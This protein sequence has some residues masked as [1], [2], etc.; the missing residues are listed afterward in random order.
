MVGDSEKTSRPKTLIFSVVNLKSNYFLLFSSLNNQLLKNQLTHNQQHLGFNS[1]TTQNQNSYMF[2]ESAAQMDDAVLRRTISEPTFKVKSALQTRLKQRSHLNPVFNSKRRF[3]THQQQ[4]HQTNNYGFEEIPSAMLSKAGPLRFDKD[5][6]DQSALT[7]MLAAAILQQQQQQQQQQNQ[8]YQSFNAQC[9]RMGLPGHFLNNFASQSQP[10]LNS[11]NLQALLENYTMSQDQRAQQQISSLSM[12]DLHNCQKLQKNIQSAS[13]IPKFGNI[14][15]VEEDSGIM[16][17]D[18]MRSGANDHAPFMYAAAKPLG[19]NHAH[20]LT[21]K[22]SSY[23]EPFLLN[24]HESL[25]LTAEC[26]SSTLTNRKLSNKNSIDIAMQCDRSYRYT[27]GIVY[28]ARMIKHECTCKNSNN[29]IETPDRLKAIYQ[30]LKRKNLLDDCEVIKANKLASLDDIALCHN[31]L[32]TTIFGTNLEER[33]KLRPEYFQHYLGSICLGE[34]NGYALVSDQDNS[35][36]EEYTPV[37]CRAAIAGTYDLAELVW[38]GKLRNGF[39]LVR[40][41]GSHAEHNKP[42]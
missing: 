15:H 23:S 28:D 35:W 33:A 32:Y 17:D 9:Q 1:G 22:L 3:L 31:E 34:C 6:E 10:Y 14:V 20:H 16:L 39:A 13:F 42:L 38:A 26:D 2:A 30:R 29:H 19:L 8:Q 5:A 40:P 12:S 18:E 25:A 36:N 7:T 27:T 37:A 11:I 41:P 21:K 24:P 4:D